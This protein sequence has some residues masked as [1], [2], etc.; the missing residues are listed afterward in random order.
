ME[1][2]LYNVFISVNFI[3]VSLETKKYLL[4]CKIF[5]LFYNGEL[6]YLVAYTKSY[7]NDALKQKN[8]IF[9]SHFKEI[10]LR[11]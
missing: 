6:N 3:S 2:L 5:W 10:F 11:T 7:M 8:M 4:R 9:S 1:S